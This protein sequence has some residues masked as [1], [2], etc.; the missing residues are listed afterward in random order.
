MAGGFGKRLGLSGKS[1]CLIEVLGKPVIDYTL[2]K[3]LEIQEI[4]EIFVITNNTFY[5]DF[6][7]WA[8]NKKKTRIFTDGSDSEQNKVGALTALLNFL[9]NQGI[10]Q[11]FFLGAADHFFDFSLIEPYETFRRKKLDLAVFYDIKDLEQAKRLGVARLEN[12]LIASFEEKPQNPKL[13]LVSSAMYFFKRETIPLIK[14][15]KEKRANDNLGM[16]LSYLHIRIP[17]YG[18]ITSGKNVD[19]GTKEALNKLNKTNF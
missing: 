9:E 10:N 15:L 13:T 4:Q 2:D 12:N 17:I 6:V 14:E 19:I 18:Y 8:K 7:E 1:K 3:L 16:L 11:D 5:Q